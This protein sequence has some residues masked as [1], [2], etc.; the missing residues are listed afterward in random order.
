MDIIGT[1]RLQYNII[2]V[3]FPA[4][5]WAIVESLSDLGKAS[6]W[7][8]WHIQYYANSRYAS[9]GWAVREISSVKLKKRKHVSVAHLNLL[10]NLQRVLSPINRC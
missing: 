9:G 4:N 8:H 2:I 6:E 10:T 5:I 3:S 7:Y 1:G